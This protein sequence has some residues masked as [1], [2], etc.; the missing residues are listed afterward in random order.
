MM[1][2]KRNIN[3]LLKLVVTA[4]LILGGCGGESYTYEPDNEL[5]P[6]PGMFSG[7]DGEFT[8]VG[9]PEPEKEEQEEKQ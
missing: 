8:L 7:Q 5:K 9:T 6:G 2:F 3:F 1:N 4:C